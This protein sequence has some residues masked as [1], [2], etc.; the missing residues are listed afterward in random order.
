LVWGEP[1]AAAGVVEG[2]IG[3]DPRHRQRMAVVRRGGKPARTRWRVA[4]RFGLAAAL[5]VALDTGRTHQIRVHLAHIGHP[6]VGDRVY[7]GRERKGLSLSEAERSLAE[8]LLEMLPRQALHA[9][10][11]E[12]AHPVTGAPLQF[13]APLPADLAG[14]LVR[15][16]AFRTTSRG[17][18]AT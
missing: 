11:L 17:P 8:A 13:A 6:V 5:E 3:R 16:K 14:A 10:E 1:R 7:G 4:E 18:T 2:A 9:A 12:L 15:L